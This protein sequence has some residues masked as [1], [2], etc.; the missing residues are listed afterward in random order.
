MKKLLI[1][2][3]PWAVSSAGLKCLYTPTFCRAILTSKVGQIDLVFG[4]QR[5][6]LVAVG[7]CLYIK[8][9]CVQRLRFMPPWLT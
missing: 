3:S 2:S 5:G 9:L 7:L 6:L 1:T 4:V 8:C